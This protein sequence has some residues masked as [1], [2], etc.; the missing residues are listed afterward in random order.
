MTLRDLEHSSS[1]KRGSNGGDGGREGWR[2]EKSGG[3]EQLS[4]WRIDSTGA[5]RSRAEQSALLEFDAARLARVCVCVCV[6]MCVTDLPIYLRR[7]EGECKIRIPTD[8]SNL[9]PQAVN[10]WAAGAAGVE[11]GRGTGEEK[12]A[13]PHDFT[14][15]G[16]TADGKVALRVLHFVFLD[17]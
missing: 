9:R 15:P 2:K 12:R 13:R 11:R 6:C 14:P 1:S 4:V 3:E 5:A 16:R 7:G 10:T 17:P 8:G